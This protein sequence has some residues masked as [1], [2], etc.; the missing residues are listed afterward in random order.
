MWRTLKRG[1]RRFIL[2]CLATLV[3]ELIYCRHFLYFVL[4]R[5]LTARGLTNYV[6][7]RANGRCLW[8]YDCML[9]AGTDKCR[10]PYCLAPVWQRITSLITGLM[11][12]VEVAFVFA[13]DYVTD[14][15][16]YHPFFF[17]MIRRPPRSTL[18]PYTTLF[19]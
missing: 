14:I 6:L 18:F 13:P 1:A 7:Q 17:L 12:G 2:D 3:N 8:T 16:K 19:R 10:C 15:I 9:H 4:T 5:S 11:R